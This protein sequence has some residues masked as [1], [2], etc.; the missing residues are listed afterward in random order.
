M[1]ETIN[2]FLI[3]ELIG[4]VAFACSGAMVAVQKQLDLLGVIV[5]GVT[6]AVGGGMLRDLLIGIHP[7]ILFVKPVYVLTAFLAVL[8]LFTI[9][10][11]SRITLEVLKSETYERAMN[12]MD[13]IGLGAFT[14]TGI[15]TAV[16]A[17]LGDYRFLI[18]FLGSITGVGGGVLRDIMAG[19]T[20]AILKKHI[21][22]CASI[23]GAVSYTLL[24]GIIGHNLAMVI[25]AVLV[26]TIRILARRYKW[27]LPTA[28]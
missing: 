7:P 21:Y 23:A 14:V 2:I 16:E 8:V 3:I 18:I 13:A 17:G 9:I 26:V 12:L 1:S 27:N 20:P 15:D 11:F 25:S 22:A 4:P 19:Q 24:M 5:L 6:T 28:M 10:R